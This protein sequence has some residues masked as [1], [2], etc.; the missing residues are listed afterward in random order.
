MFDPQGLLVMAMK[1]SNHVGNYPKIG[2][3]GHHIC[4][5]NDV[6]RLNCRRSIKRVWKPSYRNSG[7][8]VP[9]FRLSKM[10][11]YARFILIFTSYTSR[12]F[13]YFWRTM[14]HNRCSASL[15]F[16]STIA[17][18]REIFVVTGFL[19][20]SANV[21]NAA[22][23][24]FTHWPDLS[25]PD[26][27][28]QL[29]ENL[30]METSY[31]ENTR[32]NGMGQKYEGKNDIS[33]IAKAY[34]DYT[35]FSRRSGNL[36]QN[37]LGRIGIT[38]KTIATD[39]RTISKFQG[40]V[41]SDSPLSPLE[42]FRIDGLN[43]WTHNA[44]EYQENSSFLASLEWRLNAPGFADK[45]AFDNLTWGDVLQV[46]FFAD[47]GKAFLNPTASINVE[48]RELAG[49]GTGLRLLLPGRLTANFQA[50]YPLH[51]WET[52]QITANGEEDPG[53]NRTQY[54]FDFS[55]NF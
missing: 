8:S 54:W 2:F 17:N 27:S 13:I 10:D 50:A 31:V 25:L 14:K 15:V 49:I 42:R 37:L 41:I 43:T 46:S 36:H 19:L 47:Y 7:I 24:Y 52:G 4:L 18:Y 12:L 3:S 35:F 6:T 21:T 28:L 34:L 20:L 9:E 55:Y 39:Y 53:L 40:G 29:S 1:N 5:R 32:D 38:N 26:S 23:S 30:S 44:S 51:S 16:T 33:K 11:L 45:L 22:P 48:K